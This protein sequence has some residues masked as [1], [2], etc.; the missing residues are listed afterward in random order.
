MVTFKQFLADDIFIR[1]GELKAA[2][3]TDTGRRTSTSSSINTNRH[4]LGRI[5]SVTRDVP[6]YYA[7]SYIPS[8]VST[9]I[10]RSLK[11]K[12]KYTLPAARRESFIKD[13][14]QHMAQQFAAMKIKPDV[15]VAP[16]SSSPFLH[17][18]A[19]ALAKEMRITSGYLNAF[20]K[21]EATNIPH[22]KEE[23]LEYIKR[24][25]IDYDYLEKKF[26]GDKDKA[27]H[28]IALNVFYN[29]R[30]HDGH[31]V[32]K[33]IFKQYGKFVMGFMKHDLSGTDEYDLLDK[34]VMVVDDVL[35]SG[36]TFSELFRIVKDELGAKEVFG[37]AMF[38]RTNQHKD[39]DPS[40]DLARSGQ[41]AK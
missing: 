32:A 16:A 30:K 11:G 19:E 17:D 10:L 23:A 5:T 27:V 8:D 9:E 1:D 3:N 28:D 33:E 7:F 21:T 39:D 12:G 2:V 31:L 20:S 14:T 36:T 37:A 25:F 24:K 26:K 18:F 29:I 13:A 22:D 34:K 38:S 41:P 15:I 35:S 6:V 40:E 4:A